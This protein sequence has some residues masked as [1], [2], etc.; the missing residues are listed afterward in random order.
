[1]DLDI[2]LV[3]F[4]AG[5]MT[6][7][8]EKLIPNEKDGC[9]RHH[10]KLSGINSLLT[11]AIRFMMFLQTKVGKAP[12]IIPVMISR[13]YSALAHFISCIH[14]KQD[15]LSLVEIISVPLLQ[16]L[17]EIEMQDESTNDQFQVLWSETL[18][19]LQRSQ[20]PLIFDSAFL[21]L[22]SPLLEKLLIILIHPY[23]IQQSAFGIQHMLDY[24]QNLLH[25]LDK[26]SRK[27][28]VNLHKKSQAFVEQCD[29][30][31][32]AV[33]T[34]PEKYRAIATHNMYSKRIELLQ[35]NVDP[36]KNN[37]K[38]MP[39]L[40]LKRKRLELTE[41]QKEVRR[42]QQG[43]ERDC[44]GHGLG[45]IRTYTNLDFSQGNEDSLDSQEIWNSESILD[46]PKDA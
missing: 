42:A 36:K 1:M 39:S 17:A 25:V 40:N 15:V 34:A 4:Y 43:R 14:L 37:E 30:R 18:K 26:L 12:P 33:D 45:G 35:G 32:G 29:S 31:V 21:K 6:C 44:G 13:I 46:M 28:K 27:G 2:D 5:A 3:S 23:R 8:L 9:S 38:N 16:W 41:H 11:M 19:C 10:K 22:Q 20:P 24:P 7:I